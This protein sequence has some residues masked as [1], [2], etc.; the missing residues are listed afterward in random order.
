MRDQMGDYPALDGDFFDGIFRKPAKKDKNPDYDSNAMG[1]EIGFEA[2]VFSPSVPSTPAPVKNTVLAGSGNYTYKVDGDRIYIVQSG[3]KNGRDYSAAPREVTK[4][5]AAYNAIVAELNKD[6]G[7]DLKSMTLA[8]PP[9]GSAPK[10]GGAAAGGAAA[11]PAAGGAAVADFNMEAEH[12]VRAYV[13]DFAEHPV[14][15]FLD[16]LP[17]VSYDDLTV[18][19]PASSPVNPMLDYINNSDIL[20]VTSRYKRDPA[21][22][23]KIDRAIP[24]QFSHMPIEQAL[25]Q[26]SFSEVARIENMLDMP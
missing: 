8:A 14:V 20:Y 16:E 5:T 10:P 4:G 15:A 3:Y 24:P 11:P 25:K 6:H 9:S 22:K 1:Q 7:L 2:D 23:A 21:I 17:D 18:Q 26:M 13:A 12:P 19:A